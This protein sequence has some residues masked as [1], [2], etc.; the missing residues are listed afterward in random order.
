MKRILSI[1]LSAAAITLLCAGCGNS[2]KFIPGS[3][4]RFPQLNQNGQVAIVAHRGY[5]KCPEAG[6]MEN[7]IAS[8]RMAQEKGLW[9]S[10]FDI[11]LTSDDV[12][13]VNHNKD[14]Q[15]VLIWDN[16]YETFAKMTLKNGEHP[17]TLDQYLTQGEKCKTT[18]LVIELKKQK[19][20]EREDV[21]WTKTV[22]ALKAHNLY[23]PKRVI[24][25]TFSKHLCDV[26]AK[27]A[28][29][30]VNQYL[31]GDIAPE[32]LAGEKINGID[33]NDRIISTF[34][35]Y[36]K[37][38]HS[39]GMSVNVW[40]VDQDDAMKSFIYTGV[41]AITTNEPMVARSVLGDKEFKLAK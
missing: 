5:W 14:I 40:T 2:K 21:L 37:T 8:L 28:P 3:A 1:I 16:P 32:L 10:E 41:D 13:I 26:I 36:V 19:N 15:K 30:F 38:A 23:D 11:Q 24:F 22:E 20:L 9:G 34:P 12:V 31:N 18:M 35:D 17:S 7:T 33:Y 25:I 4:D 27:E 6:F 29:Q 39:K